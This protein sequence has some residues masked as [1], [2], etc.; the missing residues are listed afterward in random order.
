M[1]RNF[2]TLCLK[3][4]FLAGLAE[5]IKYGVIWDPVFFVWLEQNISALIALEQKALMHAIAKCCEIKAEV[6]TQDEHE[7]NLR[8]IL[9]FGHT[10]GHAIETGM[11]YGIYLHGEAVAIGMNLAGCCA[12]Q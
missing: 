8:K 2:Y 10:F 7:Q 12:Y 3:D 6:V 5:V 1:I 9:N 4:E 11:G